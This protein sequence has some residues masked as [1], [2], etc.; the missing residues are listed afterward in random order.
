MKLLTV[1]AL[2]SAM[3]ALTS[4]GEATS[5]AEGTMPPVKSRL[6]KRS[7]GCPHG[8]TEE[9]NRCFRY[10]P[11][12]L[13]WA[14]AERNCL[15]MGGH[16][17]S[18]RNHQEE[19]VIRELSGYRHAWIGGTD[20]PQENFWFWSDGTPFYYSNWCPGEPNNTFLQHCLQ[21]NYRGAKCWDDLWCSS[22]LPSV[23]VRRM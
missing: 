15:S 14:R 18:V 3:M 13:S 6:V 4:A 16:L 19:H 12:R 1:A 21:I 9:G 17:A 2:L 8:W 7:S 10:I 20:A 23:C 22:L 5:E 11:K